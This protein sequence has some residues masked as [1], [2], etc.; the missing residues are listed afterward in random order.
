MFAV[1][2]VRK[3]GLDPKNERVAFLAA[4]CVKMLVANHD[5]AGQWRAQVGF[6]PSQVRVMHAVRGMPKSQTHWKSTVNGDKQCRLI[7]AIQS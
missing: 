4:F 5:A 7:R 3:L 2:K 6:E 1:Q